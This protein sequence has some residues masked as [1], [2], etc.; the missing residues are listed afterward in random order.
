M[1]D[2]AKMWAVPASVAESLYPPSKPMIQVHFVVDCDE[3][4]F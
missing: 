4:S 3:I 1:K 2:I